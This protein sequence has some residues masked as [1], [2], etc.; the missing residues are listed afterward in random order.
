[1][2]ALGA[3]PCAEVKSVAGRVGALSLAKPTGMVYDVIVLGAGINGLATAYHLVRRGAG[4]VAVLEQFRLGHHRGSSHGKSRITRSSYSSAKYVELIQVA[5]AQEWP[6]WSRDAG[7]AL[8][9]PTDGCFFG[10]GNGPYLASLAAAAEL[11]ISYEVLAPAEARRQFP[12]FAFPDSEQVIWDRTSAVV[13][14][15]ETMRFLARWLAGRAE[16]IEET[17]VQRIERDTQ[18]IRLVTDR[19]V[20][21]CGRLVVT[22]GAWLG[23]LLPELAGKLQVAHQDV[24]YFA[25][26]AADEVPVW[27]YCPAEGDSFY[28]LPEFGR[29]G[30]KV[31]RHRTGA[32]GDDPDRPIAESML[33]A[34][35][36]EL[37][38]F[39]ATQFAQ[40]ARCVGYEA[41][42]YTNTINEDFL[43]DHHPQDDRI[44]IGSACSGHG[45]KFGPLTGRLLAEL[46]LDGQTS[47]ELFEKH[48]SAFSLPAHADWG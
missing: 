34:V 14:A 5:H 20:Y 46:L 33:P 45:F 28:G 19:G 40:P 30:I 43:L 13:A 8:L 3:A 47:L 26:Q 38:R 35:H 18:E 23:R 4:R 7:T 10:P 16:L 11:G 1:M 9:H 6:R 21:R 29:A 24:G 15:E 36:Q 27:V 32:E 17:A 12:C 25:I 22:A 42:L 41:C 48:R 31:A 2:L 37:E 39:V 44:V